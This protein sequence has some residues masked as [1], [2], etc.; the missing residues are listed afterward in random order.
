MNPSCVN[1]NHL[2]PVTIKENNQ[3]ETHFKIERERTHCN[4]VMFHK[5]VLI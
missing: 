5:L 3:S 2:E 1:P 4:V